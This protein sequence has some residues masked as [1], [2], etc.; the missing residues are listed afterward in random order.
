MDSLQ[1]C[2]GC[3]EWPE[4]LPVCYMELCPPQSFPACFWKVGIKCRGLKITP[5]RR[6]SSSSCVRSSGSI[7]GAPNISNAWLFP[8]SLILCLQAGRSRIDC[9]GFQSWHIGRR[10]NQEACFIKPHISFPSLHRNDL[11]RQF[12]IKGILEVK[13]NLSNS[14]AMAYRQPFQPT[15]EE[16]SGLR[17][18]PSIA[19]PFIG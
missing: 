11:N 18:G 15:N 3:L 16:Y 2:S 10:E 14:H 7:Y 13:A 6:L 9:C 8:A 12:M 4:S 5:G 17:T 1:N 19:F